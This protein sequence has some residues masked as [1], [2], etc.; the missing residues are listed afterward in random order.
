MSLFEYNLNGTDQTLYKL[1]QTF[2][3]YRMVYF[4]H[5][6]LIQKVAAQFICIFTIRF[7]M[8]AQEKS[9]LKQK[10][11]TSMLGKNIFNQSQ[12]QVTGFSAIK[13]LQKKLFT[14]ILYKCYF[15]RFFKQFFL[16]F[17]LLDLQLY[18]ERTSWYEF[19]EIF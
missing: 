10:I 14:G 17:P 18:Q 12:N 16:N 5:I 8:V 2:I 15:K 13:S 9:S 4:I 19:L 3:G 7:Q 11:S 6:Y 1:L